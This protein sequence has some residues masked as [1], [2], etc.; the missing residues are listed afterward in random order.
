[1]ISSCLLMK[2]IN[3]ALLLNYKGFLVIINKWEGIV[4]V[5]CR[6]YTLL[7]ADSN[8]LVTDASRPY[9][10]HI[11]LK[12]APFSI[13]GIHAALHIN[14]NGISL[15]FVTFSLDFTSAA[16]LFSAS[17]IA[18]CPDG[19]WHQFSLISTVA[20]KPSSETLHLRQ[21][22][23]GWESFLASECFCRVTIIHQL[24][25]YFCRVRFCRLTNIF[26]YETIYNFCLPENAFAIFTFAVI[27]V[28]WLLECLMSFQFA[29]LRRMWIS[30][31]KISL[32]PNAL[33]AS[34]F[35]SVFVK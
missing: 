13:S 10:Q 30:S 32:N 15:N 12:K 3:T 11:E 34:H 27:I 24:F 1:M 29:Y 5:I 20:I 14:Q 22:Y 26:I 21:F 8:G 18:N 23:R 16:L 2:H 28:N 7:S 4:W 9:G 6:L 19:L 31:L 33:N 35:K 17:L 25:R